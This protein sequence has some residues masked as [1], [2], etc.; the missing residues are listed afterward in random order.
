MAV[1]FLAVGYNALR[2][3]SADGRK[4]SEPVL[5]KEGEVFRA[6]AIGNGRLV[7]V[8]T[9]GGD[10]ILASKGGGKWAVSKRTGGW[11]G[12]LRSLAFVNGKFLALGGDPGSVGAAAP[13]LLAS[14]DGEKWDSHDVGGKFMLR[15]LAFGNKLYVGVGDRGRRSCSADAKKW[16]DVAG[17]KPIETLID[18]AFGAGVFVGVGLH[19]LRMLTADGTR[20]TDKQLGEEGE[21]LNSV[22]WAKDRF[23]AVGVGATLTSADGKKW[24]RHPNKDAPTTVAWLDGLFVGVRWKGRLMVSS[25]GIKWEQTAKLDHHVEAVAGG[26]LG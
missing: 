24:E 6:A 7:A 9:Y 20:W 5:G 26:V 18:V 13:Y 25:D 16:Q 11:G 4:W 15:R 21:H 10:Q 3:T 14:A 23:V 12:Y 1:T 2:C 8:G 19:G 22:V 17:T